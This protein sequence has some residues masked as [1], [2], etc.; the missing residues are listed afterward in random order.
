VE[1]FGTTKY[2]T[3]PRCHYTPPQL[4]SNWMPGGDLSFYL[5][6]N[7]DANR[8]GLLSDIAKG[9]CYLHSRKV[10]HGDLKGFNILVDI[11]D[12][13]PCARI[14]DFGLAIVTQNLDSIRPAT[15]QNFNTPLWSAPEVLSGENP[16]K[17]SDIYSFTMIMIEVFT[18]QTPFS[19]MS[20]FKA[21]SAILDG[22]RPPRPPHPAC[23]DL[24]WALMQRCWD[25]DPKLRPE[26]S[27]VLEIFLLAPLD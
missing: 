3:P 12:N 6:N 7:P 5:K 11:I 27:D 19:D 2:I 16:S 23:T 25:T 4:I 14:A 15:G 13:S 20:A 18:N 22:Q 17:E 1:A 10:I 8:L 21:V 24:L 26:A 9:L